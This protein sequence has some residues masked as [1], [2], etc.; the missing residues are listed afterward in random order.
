MAVNE[1]EHWYY[2]A[3]IQAIETLIR[4]YV[5]SDC[6]DFDILDVGCGTG[7]TSAH[8]SKL[9]NV[10][11]L[12]PSTI[13]L[14]LLRNRYPSLEAIRGTIDDLPALFPEKR[15]HLVTV[16]GV[17][18][19]RRVIDAQ[20]AL[21]K[22]AAVLHDDGW[23]IWGDCVYP[24]LARSHDEAVECER[25]FYPNQMH[26]MLGLSQFNVVFS[27]HFLGWGF[28]VA[29]GMA[30]AHRLAKAA[31]LVRRQQSEDSVDD[32]APVAPL[33]YLLH[34]LTY[35]EWLAGLWGFKAPLGVSR[36]IL[37]RK[38]ATSS[39]SMQ[40][41]DQRSFGQCEVV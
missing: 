13:A 29:L 40:S 31:G 2:R 22:V 39:E 3:R 4:R 21:Q 41:I 6:D 5:L 26:R 30:A 23:I 18:N 1:V 33:N 27:S 24:C 8:L 16:L 34:R 36:L 25:R 9:G 35:W 17:L 7:G 32:H 10:T 12:E 15:F 20:D 38:C 11:G 14:D 28:P 37:A 19:H